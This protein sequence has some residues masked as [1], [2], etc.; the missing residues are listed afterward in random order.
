MEKILEKT[1]KK[2]LNNVTDVFIFCHIG[3][4]CKAKF[5]YRGQKLTKD[6]LN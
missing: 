4:E 6:N 3:W 1:F 5:I 2:N